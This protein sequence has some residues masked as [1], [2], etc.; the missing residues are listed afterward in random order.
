MEAHWPRRLYV[1]LALAVAGIICAVLAVVDKLYGLVQ[2]P[3]LLATIAYACLFLLIGWAFRN[4]IPV[5]PSRLVR[6]SIYAA[7]LILNVLTAA[8]VFAWRISADPTPVLLQT[9]LAEGDR[10]LNDGRKDEAHLIYK[11]ALRRYPKAYPVLMRMGAVNY[12]VGDYDRARGFYE[13]AVQAAPPESRWRAL[14]D[15]GQTYWKLQQPTEA[16]QL[17]E[18]ARQAGLPPSE[19]VEWHYRLA[20]A[21]FDERDYDAA[22]EHYMAV[23]EAGDKYV[24]ASYYNAACALAQKL[25]RTEDAAERQELAAQAVESLRQAWRSTE[26]EQE[27]VDLKAGLIGAEDTRDPE[28]EPLRGTGPFAQLAKELRALD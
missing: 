14:N 12:Q 17:Y 7:V 27:R 11:D 23:A 3:L 15:L 26:T 1:P 18:R 24:S 21:Y 13:R 20:W 10:L 6:L 8:Y 4:G 28:L 16:I 22:V 2:H 25:K 5:R 19:V 9:R